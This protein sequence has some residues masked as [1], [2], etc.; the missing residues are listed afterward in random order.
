MID[1]AEN[2]VLDQC[3]EIEFKNA[4]RSHYFVLVNGEQVGEIRGGF[5]RVETIE[6]QGYFI[7]NGLEFNFGCESFE[8]VMDVMNTE[9]PNY[10]AMAENPEPRHVRAEWKQLSAGS[11]NQ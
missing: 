5:P 6:W 11:N 9:I 8:G 7:V 2:A 3:V 10:L 1:R 4:G